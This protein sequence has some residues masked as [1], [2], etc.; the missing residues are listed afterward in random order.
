[1]NEIEIPEL[2]SAYFSSKSDFFLAR[3]ILF[4]HKDGDAR[5]PIYDGDYEFPICPACYRSLLNDRPYLTLWVEAENKNFPRRPILKHA[6]L[7]CSCPYGYDL[8]SGKEIDKVIINM[9]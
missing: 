5:E 8:C 1:M 4:I 9:V 6:V 3:E 2:G 7:L